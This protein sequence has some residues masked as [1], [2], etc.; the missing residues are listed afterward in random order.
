MEIALVLAWLETRPVRIPMPDRATCEQ[1]IM[2]AKSDLNPTHVYCTPGARPPVSATVTIIRMK[3]EDP[4][5]TCHICQKF[6]G[7]WPAK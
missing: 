1:A 4:D 5:D 3:R 6:Y 7:P 2:G